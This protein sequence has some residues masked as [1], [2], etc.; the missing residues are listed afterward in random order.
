MEKR[1]CLLLG[2]ILVTITTSFAQYSVTSLNTQLVT[3]SVGNI[4]CD[5]DGN[6]IVSG[7]FMTTLT[8]GGI[9]LTNTNPDAGFNFSGNSGFIGKKTSGGSWLWMKNIGVNSYAAKPGCSPVIGDAQIFSVTTDPGGNIYITGC[10]KGSVS[11]DNITLISFQNG[12][13][14]CASYWYDIFTAKMSPSGTFLWAKKEG[15][16]SN[17]GEFGNSV[18]SDLSGNV[19]TTG[20]FFQKNVNTSCAGGSNIS[21]HYAYLVKYNFSGTKIWEKKYAGNSANCSNILQGRR[22]VSDGTNLYLLG[23]FF[24]TVNFGGGYSIA[25]GSSNNSFLVKL[26]GAGNT[27]WAKAVTGTANNPLNILLDNSDIYITGNA[28][29]GIL[30][31]GNNQSLTT[32][33]SNSFFLSKYSTAS[34]ACSWAANP[35]TI[36]VLNIGDGLVKH[37]SGNIAVSTRD[38]SNNFS[39]DE[40][41]AT[42]G[43]LVASTVATNMV[44]GSGQSFSDMTTTPNGLIYSQNLK[45]A[46]DFGGITI[47]SSQAV[48]SSYRDMLLVEYVAPSFRKTATVT[49]ALG[50]NKIS[51]FP[52]PV[53]DILYI[54]TITENNIGKVHIFDQAGREVIETNI[55]AKQAQINL[56][57]LTPGF[58]YI[59]SEHHPETIRIIK[60]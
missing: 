40:F 6:T 48:N 8:I 24:G 27:I 19:Y 11:F 2:W 57:S 42:N 37:L 47:A 7:Q 49:D 18:T 41:S 26:D 20:N 60:E 38:V 50:R 31:F 52:N 30:N 34:G 45:G 51:V 56:S 13:G 5:N 46:Y 12:G 36:S 43:A 35:G 16:S 29:Q 23:N 21:Q 10:F 28:Q 4:T 44:A 55:A 59:K 3:K 1:L 14:A 17:S 32:P 22:V 58:Y 33:G 25:A 9:T 54:S 39:I 53:K 15:T